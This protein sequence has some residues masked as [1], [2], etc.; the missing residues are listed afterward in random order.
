M[1][2][3]GNAYNSLVKPQE[4]KV[5][6]LQLLKRPRW[7]AGASVTERERWSK[8]T[9]GG[10]T[11]ET[12]SPFL[13]SLHPMSCLNMEIDDTSLKC[14][15]IMRCLMWR[16]AEQSVA[17]LLWRYTVCKPCQHKRQCSW[18]DS[19]WWKRE[20]NSSWM[21]V[22]V[23]YRSAGAVLMRKNSA[24]DLHPLPRPT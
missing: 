1:C 7:R 10:R 3:L 5:L 4:V 24:S 8:E 17:D 2:R 12:K 19:N 6:V 14:L 23:P 18:N 16:R 15:Q 22:L 11:E 20:V 13:P 21:T 9:A